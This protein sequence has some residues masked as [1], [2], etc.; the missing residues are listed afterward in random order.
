MAKSTTRRRKAPAK[1]PAAKSTAKKT[2]HGKSAAADAME[3][4]KQI[5]AAEAKNAKAEKPNE[6]AG[7]TTAAGTHEPADRAGAAVAVPS[8]DVVSGAVSDTGASAGASLAGGEGAPAGDPSAGETVAGTQS[9]DG[10]AGSDL[11]AK[12][13]AATSA[14]TKDEGAQSDDLAK[15]TGG[16]G[17]TDPEAGSAGGVLGGDG[18][19]STG[20]RDLAG[21]EAAGPLPA[22]LTG[23]AIPTDA[24]LAFWAAYQAQ[25]AI[26]RELY[27]NLFITWD[28]AELLAEMI[29]K[30]S[31]QDTL[32]LLST[33]AM[34]MHLKLSAKPLDKALSIPARHVLLSVFKDALIKLDVY[35]ET[36]NRKPA[37]PEKRPPVPVSETTLEL[38]DEPGDLS[39][40]AT[41]PKR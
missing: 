10:A 11:V 17:G 40:L 33:S 34:D 27:G 28:Q 21:E 1:K 20:D 3:A 23:D 7:A 35:Y 13:P 32:A 2:V 39:E 31:R 4:T 6:K 26:A 12:E 24:E 41:G 22:F 19:N 18:Q 8:A 30:T 14:E 5:Q 37:E 36:V 25:K 15:E 16:S 29:R 38:D 9:G